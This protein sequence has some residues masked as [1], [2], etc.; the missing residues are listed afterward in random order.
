MTNP[1]ITI[2]TTPHTDGT[3]MQTVTETDIHGAT[4]STG[5]ILDTQDAQVRAALIALGW[6]P[7]EAKR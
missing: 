4:H 7:P 6:M 3:I 5:Y 1:L 2:S